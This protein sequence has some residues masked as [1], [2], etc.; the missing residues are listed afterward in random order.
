MWFFLD[1]HFFPGEFASYLLMG[2]C[3]KAPPLKPNV[4]TPKNCSHLKCPPPICKPG[5]FWD[6]EFPFHWA[7]EV[8][9]G[10]RILKLSGDNFSGRDISFKKSK[11]QIRIV[12][13]FFLGSTNSHAAKWSERFENFN[14]RDY[15]ICHFSI[16]SY[17]R[18]I[19]LPWSPVPTAATE[20]GFWYFLV[21]WTYYSIGVSHVVN[22]LLQIINF[23][24]Q[25]GRHMRITVRFPT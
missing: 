22:R 19:F 5:A 4:S 20:L 8:F 2:Y 13:Y 14:Q 11:L 25:T 10:P 24:F 12:S 16:P 17:Y 7:I 9:R 23:G 1:I 15:I 21:V 6:L 18:T 3:S